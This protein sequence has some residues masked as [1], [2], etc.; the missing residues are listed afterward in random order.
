MEAWILCII[1]AA[2]SIFALSVKAAFSHKHT[3]LLTQKDLKEALK[4]REEQKERK[5]SD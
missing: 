5:S 3:P 1:I 2:I 4:Q